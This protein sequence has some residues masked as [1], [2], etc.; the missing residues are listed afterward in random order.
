MSDENPMLKYISDAQRRRAAGEYGAQNYDVQNQGPSV[1]DT[2]G[3]L[4]FLAGAPVGAATRGLAGT[5]GTHAP[6]GANAVRST[7]APVDA[8]S[9]GATPVFMDLAKSLRDSG[10]HGLPSGNPV[11]NGD[12]LWMDVYNRA[13]ST[14]NIW[15][16]SNQTQ[17]AAN[18][19]AGAI[20]PEMQKY[21]NA[22]LGQQR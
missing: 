21:F 9:S 15:R 13:P 1:M 5:M 10:V 7:M 19:G 22:M 8:M 14:A 6:W 16:E 11:K 4:G 2:L 12:A 3:L 20:S 17:R 18:E